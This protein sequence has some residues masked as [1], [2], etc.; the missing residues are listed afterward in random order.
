MRPTPI[1]AELIPPGYRRVVVAAPGGDLMDDHIAPVEALRSDTESTWTM[2][3]V[4]E[5]GE[6]EKLQRGAAVFL[7]IQA[8]HLSPFA[9]EVIE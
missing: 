2:R 5:D 8:Q 1:D 4:L 3:L 6:L 7:F 9:V